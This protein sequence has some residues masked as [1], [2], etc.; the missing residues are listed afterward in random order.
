M[1]RL[2]QTLERME[3][4]LTHAPWLIGEQFTLADISITPT[5]VRLDLL[6]HANLWADL[7]RVTDWYARVRSRPSFE[8][9]YYEGSSPPVE[10]SS[11]SQFRVGA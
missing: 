2:R 4:S 8:A 10:M 9:T 1:Q 11:T 3:A 7:P 6:G 5:V